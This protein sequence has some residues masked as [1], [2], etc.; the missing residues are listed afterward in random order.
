MVVGFTSQ[1]DNSTARMGMEISFR[2]RIKELPNDYT[3]D[4]AIMK[5]SRSGTNLAQQWNAETN[6]F[7]FVKLKQ[8]IVDATNKLTTAGYTVNIK[9]M[10]WLQGEADAQN[11]SYTNAYQVNLNNF[12]TAVRLY[13]SLPQLPIV[14][15]GIKMVREDKLQWSSNVNTINT[16]FATTAQND[17]NICFS[18]HPNW[19][20][21]DG[22][23]YD[24]QGVTNI[25]IDVADKMLL[26]ISGTT[27]S[28]DIWLTNFDGNY[29]MTINGTTHNITVSNNAFT[30]NGAKT[31]NTIVDNGVI[32][33]A[34]WGTTAPYISRYQSVDENGI[35]TWLSDHEP[36]G[37][38][39]WTP[40]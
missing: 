14:L 37:Q 31:I 26:A 13:V 29:I 22:V 4:I 18:Y 35:I 17:A 12:I 1:D 27:P 6:G 30:F 5:I 38:F 3:R 40:N 36:T 2:D 19:T 9:G 32:T 11:Q 28:N 33:E 20:Q 34:S 7:L 25:G 10:V 24:T 15:I 8:S 23:H 21:Y 39:I 16:A